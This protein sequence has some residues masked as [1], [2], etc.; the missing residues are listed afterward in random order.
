MTRKQKLTLI[1]AFLALV[2]ATV[3][4]VDLLMAGK[5]ALGVTTLA[6]AAVGWVVAEVRVYRLVKAGAALEPELAVDPASGRADQAAR[7]GSVAAFVVLV[8]A[9]LYLAFTYQ[10][11]ARQPLL[12][13]VQVAAVG[14]M[15]WARVTFG[16]RSFHASANA[17]RGGLVTTGPY[18]WW[19]H[20]IYASIAYF[21]WAGVAS[22]RRLDAV[23]AALLA[24]A[25]VLAR[26]LLEERFLRRTYPEYGEYAARAKRFIPF[27]V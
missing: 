25:M 7:I 21:V 16:V 23:A 13:A 19:R 10:L 12:L 18:R 17:T 6:G 1:G 9:I 14:L 15:I 22:H 4:G 24:T 27:V 26:M 8:A 2:A 11:F 20:P 5:T 3:T